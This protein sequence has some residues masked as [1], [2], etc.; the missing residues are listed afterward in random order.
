MLFD[1][2]DASYRELQECLKTAS[3]IEITLRQSR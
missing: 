2:Q 3:Y 1:A